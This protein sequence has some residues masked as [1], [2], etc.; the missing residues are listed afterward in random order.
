MQSSKKITVLLLSI[1]LISNLC[2]AQSPYKLLLKGEKSPYDSGVVIHL[3]TYRVE[4]LKLKSADVLIDSLSSEIKSLSGEVAIS[5]SI[6][7]NDKFIIEVQ[8]KALN[9]KDTTI[10]AL[11]GNYNELH[12]IA[13][14]PDPFFQRPAVIWT[15]AGVMFLLF[16]ILKG[17]FD[18]N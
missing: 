9:G 6:R 18:G 8:A 5:D 4:T 14:A 17:A 10:A 1:V 16:E 15:T 7:K 11:A 2:L 13:I 3:P 12:T